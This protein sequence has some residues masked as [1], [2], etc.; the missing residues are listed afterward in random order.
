MFEPF[1]RANFYIQPRE[2]GRVSG[3]DDDD[4]APQ[5]SLPAR[6]EKINVRRRNFN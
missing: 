1:K 4:D 5:L 3:N 6:Q 2:S